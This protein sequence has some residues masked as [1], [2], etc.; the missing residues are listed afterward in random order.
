MANEVIKMMS[1][2]E[3]QMRVQSNIR[4]LLAVLLLAAAALL[5]RPAAAQITFDVIGP[6]EYD[7]PVQQ[8]PWNVFVQYAT[9]QNSNQAWNRNAR[10]VDVDP[11]VHSVV[12][13][14]KWV[15]FFTLSGAPAVGMGFELIQPEVSNRTL[16]GPGTNATTSSGLGDSIIGY[17]AFWK[18]TEGST[19]GFQT[20][21]QMPDGSHGVSDTNWKNI[22]SALW[23]FPVG[24]HFGWTGDAGWIAQSNRDDGVHPGL[25]WNTNNRFGW[26]L[27]KT[28][29]PFVALDYEYDGRSSVGNAPDLAAGHELDVG[30]GIMINYLPNQNIAFRYS[31]GVDG[32]NHGLTNEA[33]LKY[34]LVF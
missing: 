10:R 2:L 11:T 7:L 16:G 29:E 22:S 8:D 27:N 15:H 13:L 25:A 4:P 30:A 26:K 24:T 14:S 3:T 12:G 18:P 23:Y 6:H 28:F 31:H 32:S 20:F 1:S 17:V 5:P 9:Y 19:V 21:L 33:A 34:V